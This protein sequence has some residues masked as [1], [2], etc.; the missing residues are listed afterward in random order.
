MKLVSTQLSFFFT[1]KRVQRNVRAL[2]KYVAFVLIVMFAFAEVFHL[3]MVHVEG[4]E[5]SWITGL[6]WTLTV[7]STLGFG[8]ITFQTDLGRIFS[9]VVL[10]SG[11]VLLLIVLP[12]AFI[13]FFYAPWLETQIRMRAPREVPSKTK[14][15]VIICAYDT[16]APGLIARLN[17]DDI[18]YFVL[19]PD[20]LVASNLHLEGVSVVTGDVDNK[21]TYEA[22]QLINARMV[23]ANREDTVNTNIILTVRATAPEVPIAAIAGK[24]DSIDVLELSGATHVL[25][26]KKWLGEQLASRVNASHA[27]AHVIGRYKD[28][29]IAELPVHH[30]PIVGKTIRETRLREITGVSIIG[31]WERGQLHPARP[32]SVLT[33][34]SVPILIGTEE[35]FD[36]LDYLFAVYAANPNPVLV[37]GGGT[38]GRAAARALQRNDILVNI[39]EQNT[40]LCERLD[41]VCDNV[42]PGDAADYYLLESA[43]I[44]QAP[45]VL[46][47]TNDDAMNIYLAS[48]CRHLNPNLRIVSRITHGRNTEAVHRAGADFVLSYDALGVTSALSILHDR[49]LIVFGEGVELFSIELPASLEGKVLAETG[50]GARTG[51]NVIAL[52]QNGTQITNPPASTHLLP[53]S[54]L[55]MLG[56]A[57]QRKEFVDLFS[58]G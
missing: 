12:F 17:Q 56:D 21:V 20:P 22:L 33:K 36:E 51:L 30:T 14:G 13:R 54:V 11:I 24:E 29:L 53:G 55:L 40:S 2:L 10:L 48:Y 18:P 31:V 35:Q 34:V 50:I 6:Y 4:Q 45:S 9:M 28:L 42:F 47:T 3:I 43:G 16:I 32:D 49:E 46:L 26:L 38:V 44:M 37:I 52:E 8:D 1:D 57:Q 27:Q 23:F 19:E 5:H 7:M 25:P 15:H 41:T 39:V 58:K